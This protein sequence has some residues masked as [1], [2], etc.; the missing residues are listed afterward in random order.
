MN[1]EACDYRGGGGG[2]WPPSL[3]LLLSY[4]YSAEVGVFTCTLLRKV[5]G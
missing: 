3:D 2:S 1:I 5:I 4:R